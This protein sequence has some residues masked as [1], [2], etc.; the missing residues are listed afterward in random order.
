MICMLCF[1]FVIFLFVLKL[2]PSIF[3]LNYWALLISKLSC[4]G[5]F[6]ETHLRK[7]ALFPDLVSKLRFLFLI[8]FNRKTGWKSSRGD[9]ILWSKE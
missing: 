3:D 4:G 9:S 2:I 5:C 6:A 7:L 1:V 8:N